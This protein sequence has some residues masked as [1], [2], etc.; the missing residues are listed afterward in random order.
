MGENKKENLLSRTIN[1]FFS[2]DSR[3]YL[4]LIVVLGL[5]L[6]LIAVN[7]ISPSVA[8]EMVHGPHAIGIIGSGAI[9]MQ[10]QCPV[11]FYLTDIIYKIFGVNA[12]SGRFLSFFFGLLT[13][14]LVYLITKK[15]F[16]EK[17]ALI[18]SFLL[19][20]SHFHIRY[21]L[22]EMDEAMIFFILLAFYYFIKG[23]ET[24]K[25]FNLP[26]FIFM[27]VAVLIKPITLMFIPA[28]VIY[29]FYVLFKRKDNEKRKEFFSKN[30]KS[31][32][33]GVILFSLFMSPILVYN[34]LL[35]KEKGIT[36]IQFARFFRVSPEMYQGLAGINEPFR[37][38]TILQKGSQ[39]LWNSFSTLNP[40]ITL[41]GIFGIFL[42]LFS[43]NRLAKFFLSSFIIPFIFL[44][45]TSLLQTHFVIFMIPLCMSASFFIVKISKSSLRK[46]IKSRNTIAILLILIFLVNIWF[47]WPYLTSRSAIFKTRSFAIE[48]IGEN[49]IV[50]A[51]ARTYRG[52]IAFM[53]HD[54]HYLESSYFG[55]IIQTMQNMSGQ[56]ISI[57]VYFI[58]CVI[59][60]CGWGTIGNQPDF[61]SSTE[62]IVDY[63]KNNS[64]KILTID[65]GGLDTYEGNAPYFNIYRTTIT[66]KP[67]IYQLVDSTHQWFY[68]PVMW[69]GDRYD[70]YQLDRAYK[71]ML[72][73]SAY[74]ILW[75]AIIIAIISPILLFWE[76]F[77]KDD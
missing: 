17:I 33:I 59:D 47:L 1:F 6:R 67:Q 4:I 16:N 9:S 74:F 56:D 54:K 70:R 36:D 68:Y 42:L 31:I 37:F 64:E 29:F 62:W 30:K 71:S 23:I 5:I 27:A 73:S 19:A 69:K 66:S 10:N 2:S 55:Q 53:F 75:I 18:A 7:N 11:W 39:F 12:F 43:K 76:L 49:D 51:D 40:I 48:N 3:K 72:H 61:N 24:K 58:E 38:S 13:I 21:A 65:S 60:D 28:F 45:G 52:R 46:K 32:I 8:D 50:I 34:Y 41:L 63:F 15:M 44:L 26:F 25:E 77:K 20:I 22:M 57:G 14:P 35:Y